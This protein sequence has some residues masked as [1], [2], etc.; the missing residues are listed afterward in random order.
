MREPN[1]RVK[2]RMMRTLYRLGLA[3]TFMINGV[4]VSGIVLSDEWE[5]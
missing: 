4:D 5:V 2:H 1:W 3:R